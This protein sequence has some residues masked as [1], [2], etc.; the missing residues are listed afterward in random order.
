MERTRNEQFKI[1][2]SKEGICLEKSNSVKH[3]F[4]LSFITP[5]PPSLVCEGGMDSFYKQLGRL[6]NDIIKDV[7]CSR[8]G[9]VHSKVTL[10]FETFAK[11]FGMSP[12]IM[13]LNLEDH[14]S[15]NNIIYTG[16]S[17][18]MA[19]NDDDVSIACNN[20]TLRVNL[21]QTG[22]SCVEYCFHLDLREELPL[23]MDNVAGLLM[24][25]VFLRLKKYLDKSIHNAC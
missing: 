8:S 18:L 2:C 22:G 6:N 19:D 23:F 11:E 3:L 20:S 12:K 17:P 5:S 13:T 16:K 25:K 15:P 4:R 1:I 21:S 9:P 10:Y 24:K 7:V 14:T